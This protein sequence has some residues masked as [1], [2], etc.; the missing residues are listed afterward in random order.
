MDRLLQIG[1]GMIARSPSSIAN[2]ERFIYINSSHI[3]IKVILEL[4]PHSQARLSVF[5]IC[6]R[7]VN[8]DRYPEGRHHIG[9]FC[10]EHGK[11]LR[12]ATAGLDIF[13]NCDLLL[14]G[15]DNHLEAGTDLLE[16]PYMLRN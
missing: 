5:G 1:S 6:G 12:I 14:I 3:K 9:Q 4:F 16:Y 13:L 11:T 8:T 2:K 7:R 15:E 10:F